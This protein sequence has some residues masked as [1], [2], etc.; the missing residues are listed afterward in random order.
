MSGYVCQRC[1]EL[2]YADEDLF[3]MAATPYEREP[4][5]TCDECLSELIDLIDGGEIQTLLVDGEVM[6][7]EN[8]RGF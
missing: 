7:R 8:R 4:V 6:T 5:E 2:K 3:H 1:H